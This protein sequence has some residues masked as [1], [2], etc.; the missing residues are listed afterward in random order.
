[1]LHAEEEDGIDLEGAD[2]LVDLDQV[3]E[4]LDNFDDEVRFTY[5]LVI[6]SIYHLGLSRLK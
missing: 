3:A 2:Q 5:N 1:M 4:W 6:L